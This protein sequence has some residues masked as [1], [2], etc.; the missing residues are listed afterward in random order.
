[1]TNELTIKIVTS[2]LAN[3]ICVEYQA[4]RSLHSLVCANPRISMRL[5]NYRES[6]YISHARI[7]VVAMGTG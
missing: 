4:T 3:P 2:K 6:K 1:M 7:S 5:L